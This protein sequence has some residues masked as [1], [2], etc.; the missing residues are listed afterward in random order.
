MS[1]I[2]QKE[3]IQQYNNQGNVGYFFPVSYPFQVR[4]LDFVLISALSGGVSNE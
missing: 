2:A 3:A 4:T 1:Q